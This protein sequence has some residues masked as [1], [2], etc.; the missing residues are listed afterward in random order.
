MKKL[1]SAVTAAVI[2]AT[3]AI[4]PHSY[5]IGIGE[6]TYVNAAS[7]SAVGLNVEYRT[8]DEIK[9]YI[10]EHPYDTNAEAVYDIEPLL[11]APYGTGSLSEETLSSALNSLNIA[12]YI[13]GL[14]EVTLN[15]RYTEL[16]QAGAMLNAANGVMTHSPSQPSDMSDELYTLGSN[17]CGSSNIA[18]GYNNLTSAVISGWMC[19][20]NS[21][22]T[23][24]H[25]RWCLNPSMGQ[26]GFGQANSFMAMYAFD[27]SKTT[28]ASGVC[29]PAQNTPVE[30]F[31]D[32]FP[33][34]ISMGYN[35]NIS[36]IT[37]TLTKLSDSSTWTF[38]ENSS[39]GQLIVNNEG[40]GQT[41]CIIFVP[42]SIS[43]KDGDTYNVTIDG[44]PEPVSYDVNFFA[45]TEVG[46]LDH[47]IISINVP[48]QIVVGESAEI[49]VEWS[50]MAKSRYISVSN[51][52]SDYINL[53]LESVSK[54]IVTGIKA[55]TT[56]FIVTETN[57]D[58]EQVDHEVVLNI[59]EAGAET[60]TTPV[61]TTTTTAKTTTTT[62]TTAKPTT[63]TTTAPPVT[64]SDGEIIYEAEGY[65]EIS[66]FPDK[67]TYQLGDSLDLTGLRVTLKYYSSDP[68]QTEPITVYENVDPYDYPD[69]FIVDA[70]A[71]DSSQEGEC[72]IYVNC[73]DEAI[74]EYRIVSVQYFNVTVT[75]VDTT[76]ETYSYGDANAD[77]DITIADATLIMQWLADSDTYKISDIGREC[78]DVESHGDGVT[79]L[80]ALIIQ[81]FLVSSV[82]RLPYDGQ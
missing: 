67:I 31:N 68:S 48:E 81:K 25:R 22:S 69:V 27:R 5:E 78:A 23:M 30:F 35:V 73:T 36:D 6:V 37:V 76:V 18:R 21:V 42:D 63:T 11:T 56:S 65:V 64:T 45:A 74:R 16:A 80:D 2:A 46:N 62:T 54:F 14:S 8:Q 61:T 26:T 44:L 60:T 39:D 13:A 47:N 71:F 34:T 58:G 70:S 41:G 1:L 33:W 40:Y 72:P 75:N 66:Q 49:T 52:R 24:G 17:G 19:D 43:I 15:S 12:R 57:N 77:H 10:N 3:A 28:N 50:P 20:G 51:I 38:T 59:V 7:S 29:W 53:K 79:A 4:V 55:G 9:A 32:K 82:T